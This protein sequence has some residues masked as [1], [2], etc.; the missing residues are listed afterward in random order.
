MR[1]FVQ[2]PKGWP[3]VKARGKPLLGWR[4]ED[5]R[6]P[7]SDGRAAPAAPRPRE[8]IAKVCLLGDARNGKGP[9]LLSHIYGR[10]D[11]RYVATIGTKVTKE[12]VTLSK[13]VGGTT[14]QVRVT[15]LLWDILGQKQYSR[16]HPVY[17]EGANAGIVV[18]DASAPQTLESLRQFT[19]DFEAVVGPTPL[20][21]VLN[22]ARSGSEGAIDIDGLDAFARPF[23]APVVRLRPGDDA[24]VAALFRDIASRI[25]DA[26]DAVAPL[27]GDEP[28]RARGRRPK[29]LAGREG[30]RPPASRES[31][32][33]ADP[34]TP[35][36]SARVL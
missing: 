29:W 35:P 6:W 21:F 9:L 30:A 27:A 36:E 2:E 7:P 4:R 8:V 5:T 22:E 20:T 12:T 23:R 32:A 19:H 28:P 18:C 10:C 24:K 15:L 31:R 14:R 25:L 33:A 26:R 1:L 34:K 16:L 17:H 11:S 13:L 3:G